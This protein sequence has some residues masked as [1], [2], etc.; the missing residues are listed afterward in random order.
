VDGQI[1]AASLVAARSLAEG[2]HQRPGFVL[3]SVEGRLALTW[4]VY[5]EKIL[6]IVL[7]SRWVIEPVLD[8]FQERD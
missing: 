1:S 3:V 2:D 4:K 5:R 7:C 6:D 8:L